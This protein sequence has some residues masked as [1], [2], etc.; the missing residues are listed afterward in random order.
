MLIFHQ[1]F[2]FNLCYFSG[3]DSYQER[4]LTYLREEWLKA[5]DKRKNHLNKQIKVL[6]NKESEL[7]LKPFSRIHDTETEDG[8][9]FRLIF[10]HR[11]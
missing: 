3:L 1:S 5:L 6:S 9:G 10:N 4:D 8:T 11:N 2:E 7:L